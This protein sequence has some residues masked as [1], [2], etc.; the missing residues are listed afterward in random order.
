MYQEK[1]FSSSTQS[2][3]LFQIT[4]HRHNTTQKA[5]NTRHN[6]SKS[7]KPYAK[8]IRMISTL[9]CKPVQSNQRFCSP[10]HHLL[11]LLRLQGIRIFSFS[12]AGLSQKRNRVQISQRG[13]PLGAIL[14][15]QL[16]KIFSVRA[17][18]SILLSTKFACSVHRQNS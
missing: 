1:L 8:L 17:C 15:S 5:A 6:E 12:L 11:K 3:S 4:I 2:Q 7:Y 18:R 10:K 9:Y 13:L 16:C 14:H